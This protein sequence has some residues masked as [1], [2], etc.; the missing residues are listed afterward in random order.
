MKIQ[1]KTV[2][3]LSE[4][5]PGGGIEIECEKLSVRSG[6]DW[7][8]QRCGEQGKSELLAAG[9]I[10]TDICF[11]LN[12]RNVLSLPR[13][14]ETPFCDGDELIITSMLVGG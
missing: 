13:G 4:A 3:V 12:N 11:L 2:G 14:W 10:R 1:I 8:V 5:I 7:L 9:V 6:L